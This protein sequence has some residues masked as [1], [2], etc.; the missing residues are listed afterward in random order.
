MGG[1]EEIRVSSSGILETGGIDCIRS[2]SI[3]HYGYAIANAHT[4]FRNLR[5]NKSGTKLQLRTTE[6]SRE[7]IT[8]LF[9]RDCTEHCVLIRGNSST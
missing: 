3:I 4:H 8:I 1:V 2:C 7:G 9:L 6:V 5:D